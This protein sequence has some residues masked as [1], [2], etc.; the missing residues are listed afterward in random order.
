[1]SIRLSIYRGVC[2]IKKNTFVNYVLLT[3]GKFYVETSLS[4]LLPKR[5]GI[6]SHSSEC[7]SVCLH[8]TKNFNLS[9]TVGTINDRAFIFHV[10]ILYDE[11]FPFKAFFLNCD[12]D[13]CR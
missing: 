2:K 8:V 4:S 10:Y 13:R 7:L 9:L 1:M 12:L 6:K 11:A 3:N 5:G